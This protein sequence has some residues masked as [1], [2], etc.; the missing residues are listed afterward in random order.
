MNRTRRKHGRR[1]T[2]RIHDTQIRRA[3]RIAFVYR[4]SLRA[5]GVNADI[6][7]NESHCKT[8]SYIR[9]P[10]RTFVPLLFF[11]PRNVRIRRQHIPVRRTPG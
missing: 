9:E 1:R 8:L 2:A 4:L 11:L 10:R 3:A 6:A 5:R 7:R